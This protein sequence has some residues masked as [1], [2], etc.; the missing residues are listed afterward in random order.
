M[1]AVNKFKKLLDKRRPFI[2]QSILGSDSR[3][4]QP[5]ISMSPKLRPMRLNNLKTYSEEYFD[6]ALIKDRL[7]SNEGVSR[8]LDSRLAKKIPGLARLSSTKSNEMSSASA[9][10]PHLEIES[11]S[12]DAESIHKSDQPSSSS[13]A[14][15]PLL[16]PR[17]PKESNVDK[18]R[19]PSATSAHSVGQSSPISP[20]SPSQPFQIPRRPVGSPNPSPGIV[21]LAQASSETL[22]SVQIP[23]PAQ[24]PTPVQSPPPSI[25]IRRRPVPPRS[26][27]PSETAPLPPPASQSSLSLGH[28]SSPPE[29]KQEGKRGHAHDPLSEHLFLH[30]GPSTW[31]GPSTSGNNEYESENVVDV[32]SAP[33]ISESPGAADTNIYETAYM[34]EI[35]RIRRESRETQT[36]SE[37]DLYL[38]RHVEGRRLGRIAEFGRLIKEHGRNRLPIFYDHTERSED[39][40][41]YHS[42]FT[43]RSRSRH[44]DGGWSRERGDDESPGLREQFAARAESFTAAAESLT[45]RADEA[46]QVGRAQFKVLRERLSEKKGQ[47]Y[48]G[49]GSGSGT[50]T[51]TP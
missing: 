40:D 9:S 10:D 39:D 37:P 14:S 30:I 17:P 42:R 34:E 13:Q 7:L 25:Q 48:N 32:D 23:T 16:P 11:I 28:T 24:I 5:P 36:A 27:I 50:S 26:P 19:P 8:A 33:I 18:L 43:R 49:G 31:A 51:T 29:W 1:K 38:T 35:E 12:E 47:F 6:R 44:R 20:R 41:T 46:R 2:R 21:P 22:T 3:I 15:L 45:A 4:V